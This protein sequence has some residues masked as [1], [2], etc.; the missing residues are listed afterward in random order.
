MPAPPPASRACSP[1]PYPPVADETRLYSALLSLRAC[2]LCVD[3]PTG[4]LRRGV[5][6]PP[7]PVMSLKVI[8]AGYGRTGTLSLK[9]ALEILYD[10]P[11]YHMESI[12]LPA[13]PASAP[14]DLV[15][16]DAA[17]KKAGGPGHPDWQAL[18]VDRGY[19]AAVDFPICLHYAD[20]AAAF[21]TAKVVLTARP[22]DD[23]FRSWAHLIGSLY[24]EVRRW[25]WAA[26]RL[27]TASTWQTRIMFGPLFGAWD[28]ADGGALREAPCVAA[29]EAHNAEVV[30]TIPPDR[31]LVMGLGDGWGPL[32]A[33]LDLP[34]PAVPY[35]RVNAAGGVGAFMARVRVAALRARAREVVP[36]VVAAVAMAAAVVATVG[37]GGAGSGGTGG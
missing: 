26:P 37:G 3:P 20:L 13:P 31:L 8:G 35:P 28:L 30:A 21:P 15:A 4:L 25:G 34:V 23:W 16:W 1:L 19:A 2:R 9:R 22:A 6:H 32:C 24:K 36:G 5:A 17:S 18:L 11:V 12:L 10:A 33:F 27:C 7:P 14:A 29:Y